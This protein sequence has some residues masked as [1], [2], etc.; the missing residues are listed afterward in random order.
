M[1]KASLERGWLFLLYIF[2]GLG[3]F[4]SYFFRNIV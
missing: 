4:D 3:I 1:L 2:F